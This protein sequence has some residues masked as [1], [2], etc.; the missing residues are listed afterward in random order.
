MIQLRDYQEEAVDK[1]E[2]IANELLDLQDRKT[3]VF[4][5]PTG[6]GKTVMI[7][8]FMKRFAENRH[9]GKTVSF[10]WTAP[11]KL[12]TQ[13]K[14][15]LERYFAESKAL[16]C[17]YFEEL[18]DRV[19]GDNEIL[20]LNWESINQEDNVYIRD[21]EREFNLSRVIQ[22]TV[23]ENRIIV[24]IIDESHHAAGT[25]TSQGLINMFQPKISLEVSATPHLLGDETVNVYREKVISDGMIKKWVTI[26]PD[27]KNIIAGEI[28]EGIKIKSSADEST[29]EFVINVA[30]AKRQKLAKDF[31]KIGSNINPLMLIQLPDRRRG[32]LDFK[33][34]IIKELKD[35]HDI[36][37]ANGKLAIYLS[38]SK[39]NL[40]V[41]TKNDSPVEVMIFKQA[42]ALGWDCP[43]ASILV[44]FRDWQ[45]IRFSIQTI[46]RILRMP[47]LYHYENEDLNIGYIY[48][49]L[50]D[51]SIQEDIAGTY[52]TIKDAFR[53][54]VYK[55][56]SLSSVHSKRFRERTRLSPK[57]IDYFLRATKDL[58]LKNNI[59]TDVKE[60][61]RALITDGIITEPDREFEHLAEGD[62][63]GHAGETVLRVQTE[64]EVQRLFDNFVIESLSPL[65]PE[66]RSIGRIKE[67][68]YRFFNIEFP[69]QFKFGDIIT[70]MI[71]LHSEN[72]HH[73][74]EV[75][76]L[77]KE[78]YSKEV[79][80]RARELITNENWE[81]PTS[82]RFSDEYTTVE[83][84]LSILSP[85]FEALTASNVERQ[86][87]GF[88]D[89]K[90]DEINWWFKNGDRDKTFF[91]VRYKE[92]NI[93]KPFYTDWVVKY[94]DCRIGL[95]DT[96]SGITAETAKSRAEGLASYIKREKKRG[97]NLFGGIIIQKDAVYW[98]NDREEYKYDINDLIGCGWKIFS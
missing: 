55:D 56:I 89:S 38:E 58:D 66:S 26:N 41:V 49:N 79:E 9:D 12:H 11:R 85:F 78:S 76:S 71:V 17:S 90:T 65:Y 67:S 57:F 92:A 97:K 63:T 96:K 75:I 20:F 35:K 31:K 13:S 59:F 95:F 83:K 53:K 77:A 46:G 70:Q 1:L 62:S 98:I 91:A 72:I 6:S 48:T 14:E 29:N 69:F 37:I 68:I 10:I 4:K 64:S 16:K 23:S 94:S 74:H 61:E 52:L 18:V 2:R 73:F 22:N 43:R 86:F 45:S 60:I 47:E 80:E 40:E 84:Q 81:V 28:P 87:A 82:L 32:N 42:I 44:L 36:S 51:I 93:D 88:L 3:V 15:K 27:F 21:N 39:E 33:D 24:L 25:E 19:I 50:S 8:E 54:D 34:E 30:L 5:S 7:A